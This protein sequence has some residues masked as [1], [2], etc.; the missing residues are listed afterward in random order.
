MNLVRDLRR[1]VLQDSGLFC[2]SFMLPAVQTSSTELCYDF[3]EGDTYGMFQ[4]CV[5]S[6]TVDLYLPDQHKHLAVNH[7]W[8]VL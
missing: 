1:V 5:Q 6:S 3:T 7:P 2:T 8:G 4:L